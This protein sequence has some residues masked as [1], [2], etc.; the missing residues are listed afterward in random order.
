[1]ESQN[2]TK[3]IKHN[4][5]LIAG[6]GLVVFFNSLFN[7]FAWDD[8]P[9]IVHNQEIQTFNLEKIFGPS[10]FN[11]ES[12][13][14]AIPAA[15]FTI[16]YGL[17]Q[18]QPFLYHLI[19]V[20]L[21]IFCAI[22]VYL[23]FT[24][25]IP[26]KVALLAAII[27]LIHP[28]NVESVAHISSTTSELYTLPGLLALFLLTHK[29]LTKI[30]FITIGFLL[31]ASLLAKEEGL[32]ILLAIFTFSAM[33]Q[34]KQ[35]KKILLLEF[36]VSIFYLTIRILIGQGLNSGFN[37]FLARNIINTENT[38]D[39]IPIMHLS[40]FDKLLNTPAIILYYLQTFVFPHNLVINQIWVAHNNPTTIILPL[41]ANIIMLIVAVIT[42]KHIYNHNRS[43]FK[44]YMF[45]LVWSIIGLA[46]HLPI[47]I[48]ANTTV[49][50]RWFY[51]TMIG[52]L[53]MIG[54]AGVTLFKNQNIKTLTTYG[55]IIFIIILS[56]RTIIRNTNYASELVLFKHDAKLQPNYRIE[57]G[58]AHMYIRENDLKTAML[59]LDKSTML[60]PTAEGL[61][62]IGVL[63]ELNGNN[64]QASKYYLQAYNLEISKG[65][66]PDKPIY[67]RLTNAILLSHDFSYAKK[68]SKE[69]LSYF[70]KDDL[71]WSQLAEAELGLQN[72]AA[73]TNAI[74]KALAI[75]PNEQYKSTKQS[76]KEKQNKSHHK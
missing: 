39:F 43:Y 65:R 55:I 68:I 42:A 74:D 61:Y 60:Y 29:K 38:P 37:E 62:D 6:I 63:N 48:P 18:N 2:I 57:L 75:S 30:Y 28:M 20:L 11:S 8:L 7:S 44:P 54:V 14:R 34:P 64:Y 9:Y 12:Y 49:A 25:F 17:V 15:Y 32:L 67:Q 21:H 36:L 70:S 31:L 58:L 45:F 69:G 13:Y 41:I 71:L 24:R 46:F 26:G 52:L 66:K 22:F 23:I 16:L 76:I 19:Q 3:S 59:H 35:L 51:F 53:G 73:A 56:L 5:F 40:F 27:F 10:L 4:I 47:Y 50:D 1:M 33:F 72:Y